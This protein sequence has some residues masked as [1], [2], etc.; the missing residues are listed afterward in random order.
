M[1]NIRYFFRLLRSILRREPQRQRSRTLGP[2]L[3]LLVLS[4]AAWTMQSAGEPLGERQRDAR[5]ALSARIENVATHM[6][7]IEAV[8]EAEIAP[9]ERV[10]LAHRADERLAR[11]V[12]TA[13]SAESRRTDIDARLLLAVLLVENP[14]ID[15]KARSPV[16]A[17]GLMQVMPL[18]LGNWKPCE[19]RLDDV[20]ANICHGAR[21]FA[22]YLRRENGNIERALLRYNG[23]VHGTNTPNCHSYPVQV[24]ARAGRVT[25]HDWRRRLSEAMGQARG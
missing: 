14:W 3:V 16:G 13:L 25:I 7:Y 23:C 11:R 12:A 8:Y 6:G 18:H 21:I 19:P 2:L 24:L 5:S 15:P 10:L 17:Q 4:A 9:L 1:K 20:E 22:Y